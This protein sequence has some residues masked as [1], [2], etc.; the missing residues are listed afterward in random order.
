MERVY[1]Q[2]PAG[3]AA[4][5]ID[6]HWLN[7]ERVLVYSWMVVVIFGLGIVI[8]IVSS[9]PD[10]VD[11]NGKPIGYDFMAY[12]S[13]A[14][15]A[16]AG[17]LA[18]AFDEATLAAVQ[19]AAVPSSP[20][21][22]FPWHYPPIFMLP[23]AP[24]GFLP[25]PVALA[26]FVGA[27]AVLWAALVRRVLP[28]ASAWIV[29]AAAPAGLINLLDGQNAF[30]TVAL[31]GFAL[32]WLDRR[33][34]AAGVL[35]GLLAIKP[36]LAV[37]FPIALLAEARWRTIAAAAVTGLGLAAASLVAF[38]WDSWAA[39]LHHLP[40]TQAM[41]EQGA[42]PWGTMPSGYVFA[43]SL[44]LPVRAA[45][46][47]Q[48][49]AALFAACCVWRAWRNPAAAFEAKAATLA[50]G[51]LLVSPYL[52][53]Y[54]LLWAVLAIGWLAKLGLRTGFRRGEREVFLLAFLAPVLMQPVQ[55]L[56]GIQVGFPAVLL[57][58][59][60]AVRRAA[61]LTDSEREKLRRAVDTLRQARW[62][63]RERVLRWGA[64]GT[65]AALAVLGWTIFIHLTAGVADPVG[66]QL[67]SDFMN[68]WSG[69]RLAGS[70]PWLAYEPETFNAL[71]KSLIGPLSEVKLYSYSPVAMLLTWPLAALPFL[72]ALAAWTLLGIALA[73]LPLA[74]L[75]G[76]RAAVLAL[77]GAPAAIL[78]IVAGQNGHFTAAL[79]G[80]GLMLLDRRPVVAGILFGALC[81]K[82]QLG[83]VL[84]IALAVSGRYRTFAAASVTVVALCGA[85]LVLLG[86]E[87]W[88]GYRG[89]ME[90][91]RL[92]M[93]TAGE[94]WSRGQSVFLAV[95]NLGTGVGFAYAV[96]GC[97]TVLAVIATVFVWRG[98]CSL[99]LKAATLVLATFL[100]TPYAWD[101]DMVV[102][103]FVAAWLTREAMATG[104]QEWERF[105]V[106]L[107]LLLP[108]VTLYVTALTG[109]QLAPV[110]L[111]FALVISLRRVLSPSGFA[112][113]FAATGDA[114]ASIFR[115]CG[116][117][118]RRGAA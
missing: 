23:L 22:V 103:I 112:Q 28:D 88:V 56:T 40:V 48:S 45:W 51:S 43:L 91:Q 58:L 76:W 62:I 29:A 54:D 38:G 64:L 67:G 101:Y 85:S 61:P 108:I 34:I 1:P 9:L 59:I 99:G 97:S 96:Q 78:D 57:L 21:I 19:H 109:V 5:H 69:A 105:T 118:I 94:Y 13:A 70:Q 113:W 79:L 41:A 116:F 7:A 46:V 65:V 32:L 60:V 10:L 66:R 2:L 17:Q 107:L 25:Y 11:R 114:F 89:Q 49:A 52:F 8:W 72:P 83:L 117:R 31:A 98:P 92:L 80:G 37:L 74:R 16:L 71:V 36:H 77:L 6:R 75:I 24:L 39:F 26:V 50:A 110:G 106:G 87:A 81:Y 53:Y 104:F 15:L 4:P 33:P 86:P 47:L 18:T 84:P 111:W 3:D 14:R 115:G 20:D 42:V 82:P 44:G 27:T 63:G 55:M 100:A 90:L 93:E 30:L 102:L 12:W 35:I 95:H 73:A 68:F